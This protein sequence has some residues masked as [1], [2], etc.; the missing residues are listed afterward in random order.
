MVLGALEPEVLTQRLSLI[1][2]SEKSPLLEFGH[3]KIDEVRQAVRE[4]RWHNVEAIGSTGDEPFLH[5]V[6]NILWRAADIVMTAT[7]SYV[8]IELANGHVFPTRHVAQ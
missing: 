1:S 6:S 2:S 5:H 7:A 4:D 3:D 8:R